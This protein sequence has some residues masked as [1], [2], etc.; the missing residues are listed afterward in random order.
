MFL[1]FALACAKAPTTAHGPAFSEL[2][3]SLRAEGVEVS[4]VAFVEDLPAPELPPIKAPSEIEARLRE[5]TEYLGD[6]TALDPTV[7]RDAAFLRDDYVG[8]IRFGGGF[9]RTGETA[10]EVRARFIEFSAED[11]LRTQSAQWLGETVNGLIGAAKI[12]ALA[13]PA[14]ATGEPQIAVPA[15]PAVGRKGVRGVHPE[16]G[17]DNVNLPRM[18]IEPQAMPPAPE[19]GRWL[20]VP[21]LRSYYVHN[22]GWFLGQEWGCSGGARV[23]AM[24][25][26][27]DR[28]TGQPAWWQDATGRHLEEM[29]AQPSTAQMD[30]FLL[31]AED[32]V[33]KQFARGF[34]R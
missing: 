24:L 15:V 8:A 17:H 26:I 10:L 29:L 11:Q 1:L 33:E 31:W 2:R 28:R 5:G 3:S 16:D 9:I 32:D 14:A 34:L 19:G 22:G 7:P 6:P 21:Y 12:P 23:E 30:Q 13:G 18:A 25:V 27:Y 4:P 20:L